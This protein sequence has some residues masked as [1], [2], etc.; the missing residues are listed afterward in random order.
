MS[1]GRIR[2][3]LVEDDE[4]DYLL[5]R[6]LLAE[7]DGMVYTLDWAA[8]FEAAQEAIARREHDVYLLDYRLGAHSGLDLVREI[9]AGDMPAPGILLTGQS[10]RRVDVEAMEAG[11]ADYLVKGEITPALLERAIRYALQHAQAQ[12]DLRQSERR[13]RTL[14]EHSFEGIVLA[15]HDGAIHY[16][17]PSMHTLLGYTKDGLA[18]VS[19]SALVH[20]DDRA[21]VAAAVGTLLQQPGAIVH[22]EYRAVH[23]D[24]RYRWLEVVASNL[25]QEPGLHS[26]VINI[27]DS[28]ERKWAEDQYATLLTREQA[29]RQRAEKAEASLGAI[30]AGA[31]LPLVTFDR[32]GLVRSWND[33]AQR[34]FGWSAEEVLGQASPLATEGTQHESDAMQARALQGEELRDVEIR[35]RTRDGALIDLE[36]SM[37]PLRDSAGDVLGTVAVYADITAR[38]VAEDALAEERDLLHTLM[39]TVPDHI[40]FKDR[41]SRLT[42]IN[43]AHAENLGVATIKEAIGKTDI[44]FYPAELAAEMYAGEQRIMESGQPLINRLEDQSEHARR[45]RWFLATKVP[46]RQN[47]RVIGLVG[48]TRDVTQIRLAEQRAIEA[49]R[50]TRAAL[51]ALDEQIAILDENGTVLAVN[52]AWRHFAS[53]NGWLTPDPGI[54]S[55]YLAVCAE[56]PSE[57]ASRIAAGILGVKCGHLASYAQE[58]L[59]DGPEHRRWFAMRATRFGGEGPTRVVV[60]HLDITARVAAEEALRKAHGELELRVAART[61]ELAQANLALRTATAEAEAANRA[62]SDFLSRMS[63]ELRTPLN[64][65]LGFAQILEMRDLGP[66]DNQGLEYILKAGRHLLELINEVL[67]IAQIEVGRLAI[68]IEPVDLGLNAREVLQMVSPLAAQRGILLINEIAEPHGPYLQADQQRLKQVLLNLLSNAIK[69]NRTAGSVT[70]SYIT[71]DGGWLRLLVR[72]TGPGIR[73]EDLKKLFV[74]FERL[75]TEHSEVAGS[76]IGLA[77][78]KR[79]VELMGGTVGV[80][81][82]FGQGSTFWF[83]LPP[84]D[85]PIDPPQCGHEGDDPAAEPGPGRHYTVLYIEDNI[86]NVALIR[87][88][89]GEVADVQLLTTIQGRLGLELAS[90]HQPDLIL[91]DLHLP[92]IAG[93]EVLRRLQAD[94]RTRSIPVAILSAD[95]TPGTIQLLRDVGAAAYL[96][97]PIDVRQLLRLLTD[98]LV[99][100]GSRDHPT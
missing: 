63:H 83:E 27:R 78:S 14:T 37:A 96:T 35:R 17:S 87:H 12:A 9:A 60:A 23:R 4:D 20:P 74:P 97:K 80:A 92:D 81:S 99:T 75:G 57:T 54:G 2:L 66:R 38:K 76:G 88:L 8:T 21:A 3:L 100:T 44:D 55:N 77:L 47:G 90:E 36:L 95:A 72:D 59:C 70:V 82:E 29:A 53:A 48:I 32:G 25:L 28:T 68:S 26:V 67:D 10:A 86:S 61:A 42:R 43:K 62:K 56:D 30:V 50:F 85:R 89:L 16:A 98:S 1:T 49:E 46:I 31:P 6:D 39:D 91:L 45:P 34:V 18:A 7:I 22:A 40:Y 79:L 73:P 15:G 52:A 5:T 51:D 19:P 64:A 24:G 94:P 69:Y 58:Y 65:I 71:Q 33:A 41:H 11:A 84:A 13:F 93:E